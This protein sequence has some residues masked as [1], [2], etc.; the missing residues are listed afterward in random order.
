M[1]HLTASQPAGFLKCMQ[2]NIS[3]KYKANNLRKATMYY[4]KQLLHLSL[5][6]QC[7]TSNI[8]AMHKVQMHAGA[9]SK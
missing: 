8:F 6:F 5:I 4:C 1:P 9:I 2:N 7:L 3:L